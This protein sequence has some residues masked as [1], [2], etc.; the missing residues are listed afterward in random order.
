MVGVLRSMKMAALS[1]EHW[2]PLG[3]YVGQNY[4]IA[5]G[6]SANTYQRDPRVCKELGSVQHTVQSR[7]L[8]NMI[9]FVQ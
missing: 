1:C 6:I 2:T 8:F 9:N 4:S 5:K 3:H 7:E